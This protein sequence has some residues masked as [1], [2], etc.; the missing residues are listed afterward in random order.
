MQKEINGSFFE[1]ITAITIKIKIALMEANTE[2]SKKDLDRVKS[3]SSI[4]LP[5]VG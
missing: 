4:S 1:T 3:W 2:G 5:L